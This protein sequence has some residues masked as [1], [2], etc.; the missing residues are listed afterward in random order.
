[1]RIAFITDLH[2]AGENEKPMGVDV[3]QNFLNALQY[4]N[5]LQPIA[6]VIG[7]DIC[8]QKGDKDIYK[9]VHEQ[10]QEL[11]F[12]VYLI[13][14]N[15]DDV[16]LLASELKLKRHLQN[17]ELY[18]AFPMEGYPALFLDT[19]KGKMSEEQWTWLEE[20]LYALR[21]SNVLIFMHHPPVKAGVRYMDTNY[22]FEQSERFLALTKELPCH[23]TV[24]CG[25]YHVEKWM[26]RGNLSVLITPS[27]F[28]QMQHDPVEVV[29]DHYHPAVRVITFSGEGLTSTVHYV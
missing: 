14:G 18:Y 23:V 25:H 17:G 11:P 3:R 2:I 29:I 12:P 13:A 21:D 19:A 24:F 4:V 20:H 28:F 26:L 5:D 6:L 27:L 10:L 9:W 1:M 7:G 22:A 16:S 15:H 8:Y